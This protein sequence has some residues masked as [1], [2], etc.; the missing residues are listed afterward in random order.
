M[1]RIKL[2]LRIVPICYQCREKPCLERRSLTEIIDDYFCG[3][4]EPPQPQLLEKY[5]TTATVIGRI[6]TFK[7]LPPGPPSLVA[8]K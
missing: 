3:S 8:K 2:C 5:H 4:T 1:C 7:Q 6:K